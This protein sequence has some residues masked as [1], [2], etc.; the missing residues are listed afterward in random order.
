MREIRVPFEMYEK[1]F[2]LDV[3]DDRGEDLP[4]LIHRVDAAMEEFVFVVG[5][6][7]LVG[8]LKYIWQSSLWIVSAFLSFG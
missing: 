1:R 6:R 2:V 8:A 4:V 3:V 7:L 5:R